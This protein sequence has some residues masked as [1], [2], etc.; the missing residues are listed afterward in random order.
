MCCGHGVVEITIR[1]PTMHVV[2]WAALKQVCSCGSGNL[3][4]WVGCVAFMSQALVRDV[5][6][7]ARVGAG[8]GPGEVS[9]RS[10]TN[11]H[12]RFS[13]FVQGR[14]RRRHKGLLS[15]RNIFNITELFI[16]T[17]DVIVLACLPAPIRWR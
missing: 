3:L 9:S 8:D 16:D 4:A 6:A 14:T 15:L 1:G 17:T 10:P 11:E 13:H 5:Q 2:L 12:T 7:R